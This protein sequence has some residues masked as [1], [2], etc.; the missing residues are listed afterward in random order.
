VRGL[1]LHS[2]TTGTSA[3]LLRPP[4]DEGERAEGFGAAELAHTLRAVDR[5]RR[6]ALLQRGWER[7]AS[8]VGERRVGSDSPAGR[9]GAGEVGAEWGVQQWGELDPSPTANGGWMG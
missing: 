3:S 2:R 8:S 9:V 4:D 1:T 7:G 6:A 5:P